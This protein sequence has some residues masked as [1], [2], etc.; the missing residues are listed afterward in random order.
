MSVSSSP[1]EDSPLPSRSVQTSPVQRGSI[2]VEA[3]SN[4][5][6]VRWSD[7]GKRAWTAAFS[8]DSKAP[9]ISL[10]ATTSPT[11]ATPGTAPGAASSA[12]EFRQPL[13]DNTTI[14]P[15]MNAPPGTE[16]EM[17]IFFLLGSGPAQQTLDRVLAYTHKDTFPHID[18]Y[19][20]FSPLGTSLS[21]SRPSPTV[22]PACLRLRPRSNESA[23][24]PP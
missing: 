13:D 3:T 9:L 22:Q 21:R 18:G 7:A 2:R 19:V 23:S 11:W 20:T 10:R 17:G 5:I 4:A 24:T 8:L 1:S 15:W 6:T 12:S 16:Q 14:Y